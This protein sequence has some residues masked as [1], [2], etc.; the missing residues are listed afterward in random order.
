MQ[1]IRVEFPGGSQ[2]RAGSVS[3]RSL[4]KGWPSPKTPDE[5][6]GPIEE[7]QDLLRDA[8][9]QQACR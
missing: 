7:R 9:G 6:T 8:V 4:N 3:E 1:R 2:Q 5:H